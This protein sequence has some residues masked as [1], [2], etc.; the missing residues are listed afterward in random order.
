ME[1][2]WLK[3]YPKGV[4][5]EIDASAYR[6]IGELIDKN[7]VAYRDRPAYICMGK[8]L[9]FGEV[10]R[11]SAQ[12]AAWLHYCYMSGIGPSAEGVKEK[13]DEIYDLGFTHGHAKANQA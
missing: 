10:D 11:L 4:P 6:S 2:P 8:T 3:S 12:F 9:S 1:K 13:L 5:A 7:V